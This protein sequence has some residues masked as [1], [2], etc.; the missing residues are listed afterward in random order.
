MQYP[1]TI[2]T[3]RHRTF[4]SPDKNHKSLLLYGSFVVIFIFSVLKFIY[5]FPN[6]MPP[7]SDSYIHAAKE[8]LDINFWPIG[9]SKFLRLV[10]SFTTSDDI[11]VWLQYIL[12]QASTFYLLFT[13][14]YFLK[15]APKVFNIIF[16]STVLNPAIPLISNYISSDSLFISLTLIWIAQ[17]WRI[18]YKPSPTNIYANILVV[19]FAFMTR[20]NAIYYPIVSTVIILSSKSK[21]K[22]KAGSIIVLATT[23][24]YFIDSTI[25]QYKEETHTIEFSAFSGWQLASNSL[26]G[27]AHEKEIPIESVPVNLQPLQAIVKRNLDSLNKIPWGQRPDNDPYLYYFW[28]SH[29]PLEEYSY[30]NETMD[31]VEGEFKRW[32]RQGSI[33]TSYGLFILKEKPI[34]YLKYFAIP[35]LIKYYTPPAAFMGYYNMQSTEVNKEIAHWFYWKNNHLTTRSSGLRIGITRYL[36]IAFS[37]LNILYLI[38]FAST[39]LLEGSVKWGSID[40]ISKVCFFLWLANIIFSVFT[41]PIELRYQISWMIILS[42]LTYL[43]METLIYRSF[44]TGTLNNKP[45]ASNSSATFTFRKN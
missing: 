19:L 41:A 26:Y 30:Y 28:N 4:G 36:S 15:P 20:Y 39:I 23:I 42:P 27:Y 11:V 32:A 3:K 37:I 31:S 43:Y 33:Y 7:D 29:S 2:L 24:G 38:G 12:L 6:F 9:Y 13:F 1:E 45:I 14:R 5:P 25:E 16:W 44:S 17:L 22:V 18:L 35:N 40:K 21:W 10:S 8:N 34:S